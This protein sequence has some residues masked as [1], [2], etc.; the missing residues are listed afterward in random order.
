MNLKKFGF[1]QR[2]ENNPRIELRPRYDY[3][4]FIKLLRNAHFVVSDGGSNQ[5]E[6][7]YLGK[8]VI[9]LRQST[10][11]QE[12]LGKNCVLSR[13]NPQVI[14]EFLVNVEQYRHR[15]EAQAAS[16]CQLIAEQCVPFTKTK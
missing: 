15:F 5:E 13:Y 16:P 2:L 10:E 9:L 4:R 3:F 11:R 12:G 7:Y 6:C 14:T 8:P 1:Y